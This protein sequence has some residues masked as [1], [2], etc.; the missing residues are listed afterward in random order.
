[1]GEA[2]C[3]G[4]LGTVFESLGQYDKAREE[5]EASSYG[6]QGT[7]FQ[8]LGQYDKANQYLQK[9]LV[10]TTEIAPVYDLLEGPEVI[11]VPDRSLYKV[12]GL[13]SLP[14][15]R[16]EAEMVGRLTRVP[17]LVEEKAT[18]Q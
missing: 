3:H 7:V 5:G 16:T 2:S 1:Q 14:F 8:S 15:A 11:I 12:N 17:P 18:K 10:I 4:N 6:N 9:G 13:P